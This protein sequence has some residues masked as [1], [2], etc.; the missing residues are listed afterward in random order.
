MPVNEIL[1]PFY[2]KVKYSTGIANHQLRAYFQTGSTLDIPGLN[3]D[4]MAIIAPSAGGTFSINTIVGNMFDRT[5]QNLKPDTTITAIEVWQSQTG[6]NLFVGLNQLP[7]VVTY[8][9]GA[10]VASSYF[11][12]VYSAANRKKFRLTYF[13]GA[14]VSPQRTAAPQPPTIDNTGLDWYLLRSGV[15]FATQDGFRLTLVGSYN[16]GY[17]RKLARRY[18]RAV[19]P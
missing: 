13:D 6:Q 8:G 3:P 2:I 17:N 10:Q 9:T 5:K 12:T 7:A 1:A 15:P 16:T 18:G 11:T 19:T 4:N 14:A